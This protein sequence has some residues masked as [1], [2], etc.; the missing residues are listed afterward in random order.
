MIKLNYFDTT[1]QDTFEIFFNEN[2][3]LFCYGI[4]DEKDT[5]H[6]CAIAY[7]GLPA[8]SSQLAIF[9]S[10]EHM[11]SLLEKKVTILETTFDAEG[12][13]DIPCLINLDKVTCFRPNNEGKIQTAIIFPNGA[14]IAINDFIGV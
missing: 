10:F 9:E 2:A 14:A 5:H 6:K 3:I 8:E 13:T 1:E 11:K 4:L 12:K 7:H